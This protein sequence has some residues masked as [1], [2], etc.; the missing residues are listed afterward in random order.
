MVVTCE[1]LLVFASPPSHDVDQNVI[2]QVTSIGWPQKLKEPKYLI[3][4]I[5][6][7]AGLPEN[8]ISRPKLS[9]EFPYKYWALRNSLFQPIVDMAGEMYDPNMLRALQS[10]RPGTAMLLWNLIN[11]Y[12]WNKL[13]IDG[14]DASDFSR[15]LIDRH[16]QLNGI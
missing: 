10:A 7:D 1:N 14:A 4:E 3:R 6:R 13:H 8:I 16:R 12:I 9:F 5:L 15:E 11:L 2:D